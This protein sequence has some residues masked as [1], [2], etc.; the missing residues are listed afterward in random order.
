MPVEIARHR[1]SSAASNWVAEPKRLA[2]EVVTARVVLNGA[3]IRS[4][5][6][7]VNHS[8]R[9]FV[10]EPDLLVGAAAQVSV[11]AD[12]EPAIYADKSSASM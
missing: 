4:T 6:R 12:P 5:I 10:I 3:A 1:R 8:G 7:V 9:P 2:P 11:L